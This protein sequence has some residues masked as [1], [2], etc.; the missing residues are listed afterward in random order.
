MDGEQAS[1]VLEVCVERTNAPTAKGGLSTV[2][3][4]WCQHMLFTENLLGFQFTQSKESDAFA[5]Q[6]V[7]SL[8]QRLPHIAFAGRHRLIV[9]QLP[10]RTPDRTSWGAETGRA[11]FARCERPS[12]SSA[13]SKR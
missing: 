8:I 6:G 9:N 2:R 5:S 12:K 1:S 11:S 4:P 13:R 10:S 7:E 3:R